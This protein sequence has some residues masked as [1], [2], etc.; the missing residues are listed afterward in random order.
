VTPEL[1]R[2]HQ[3]DAPGASS[4]DITI[5]AT[6]GE[7]AALARRFGLPAI[8]S[9][10][11]HF[12]LVAGPG[13]LLSATGDLTAQ[14][15]QVC[16]VTLDPFESLVT[17]HFGVRFVPVALLIDDIDPEAIDEIPYENGM[18][19]LGEAAAE[20]LALCLDPYPHAP[21]VDEGD[22]VGLEPF[23]EDAADASHPFAALAARTR[24]S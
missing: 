4:R 21:G 18:I 17:E 10:A 3:A 2:P 22:G 12:R 9:L 13:G 7:C 1:Y 16:V 5:T 24:I 6:D 23:G 14:I 15:T 11:C 19:D 8:A 20:Q